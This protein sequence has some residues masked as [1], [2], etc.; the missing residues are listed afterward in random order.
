M[1]NILTDIQEFINDFNSCKDMTFEIDTIR[2]KFSK[3]HKLSSLNEL[4]KWSKLKKNSDI[5][6]KLKR[7]LND[8]EV[9][10]VYI[11]ENHNIYYYNIQEP[12]KYRN[13]M[14]VIFAMQQYHKSPPPKELI[15]KILTTLKNITDIDIC[16][17]IPTVPN[18][19]RLKEHYKLTQYISKDGVFTDTHYINDTGVLMLDKIVIYN[20]AFKNNL[21]FTVWR[22]EAKISIPNFNYLTLP[23]QEFKEIIDTAR[24]L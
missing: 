22:Y 13:A 11:L 9:T 4:G 10:S 2:V 15:S 6:H 7:R 19:N 17:D 14:M 20:K 16:F 5:L 24:G 8:D 21:G 12:P 3:Q 1:S 23:L 18:L